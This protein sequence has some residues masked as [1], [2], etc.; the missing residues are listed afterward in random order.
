MGVVPYRAAKKSNFVAEGKVHK[1]VGVHARE[2]KQ[3]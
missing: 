3:K 2:R 1:E